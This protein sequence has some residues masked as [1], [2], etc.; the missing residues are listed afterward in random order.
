MSE[1]PARRNRAERTLSKS[2]RISDGGYRVTRTQG[3]TLG[4]STAEN[5]GGVIGIALGT[6][7]REATEP[8]N[9]SSPKR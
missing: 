9:E 7:W 1:D 2:F 5:V 4:K 6:A 3:G 8:A